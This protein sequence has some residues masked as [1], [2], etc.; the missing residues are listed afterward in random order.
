MALCIV[1]IFGMQST[2]LLLPHRRQTDQDDAASQIG[3]GRHR[4]AVNTSD[5]EAFLRVRL[6]ILC[7]T[8]STQLTLHMMRTVH[9]GMF[10]FIQHWR[11]LGK[12]VVRCPLYPNPTESSSSNSQQDS[13]RVSRMPGN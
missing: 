2:R 5:Y 11:T 1:V 13:H 6:A 10:G 12:D 4:D 8:H 3:F 9:Y 7:S